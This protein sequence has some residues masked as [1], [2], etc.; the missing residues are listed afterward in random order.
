MN[1]VPV[2]QLM[3]MGST[4]NGQ[5][6]PAASEAPLPQSSGPEMPNAGE[7]AQ[8]GVTSAI[9]S[10]LGGF[11][12]FGRKKKQEPSQ[13]QP[14]NPSSQDR[15]QAGQ[16]PAQ[17]VL[18]ES[19]TEMTSFSSAPVDSSQFNIPAGYT[20]VPVETNQDR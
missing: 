13:D 5:P 19:S 11:G 18:L 7:V 16:N 14:Q 9:T 2:M 15:S 3:R 12:G 6:L 20:Q 10:K 17:S 4:A 8:K 1:G